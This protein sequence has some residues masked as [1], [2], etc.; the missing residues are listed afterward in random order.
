[1]T[2]S[3]SVSGGLKMEVF[4]RT[5]SG[6]YIYLSMLYTRTEDSESYKSSKET[7]FR[8]HSRSKD[9]YWFIVK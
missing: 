8:T 5:N 2:R 1:M 9:K 4:T 6:K 3:G 7:Q